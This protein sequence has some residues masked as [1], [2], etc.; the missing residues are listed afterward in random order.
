VN[1]FDEEL[2]TLPLLVIVIL[3]V[4]ESFRKFASLVV[5]NNS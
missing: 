3:L 2:E 5:F 1:G 4:E